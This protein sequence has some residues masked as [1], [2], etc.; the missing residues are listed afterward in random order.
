MLPGLLHRLVAWAEVPSK[1]LSIGEIGR[2]EVVDAA[3]ARRGNWL[4][5]DDGG[6]E[7]SWTSVVGTGTRETRFAASDEAAALRW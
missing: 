2:C 5:A 4:V 1:L 6:G 3:V 7:A